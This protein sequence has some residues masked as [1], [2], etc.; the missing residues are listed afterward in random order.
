MLGELSLLTR[1]SRVRTKELGV[2]MKLGWVGGQGLGANGDGEFR[3][4]L[5]G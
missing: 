2:L 4:I 3:N 5:F 1:K